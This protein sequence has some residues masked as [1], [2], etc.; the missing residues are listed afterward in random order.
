MEAFPMKYKIGDFVKKNPENWVQNDFDAWGRGIGIAV[1]VEPP[2]KM[3]DDEVD[4]RWPGGRCF[5][6]ISQLLPAT[7]E[8]HKTQKNNE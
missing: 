7:K 1:V 5:E 4:V 6:N 8:E 3:G 2:F